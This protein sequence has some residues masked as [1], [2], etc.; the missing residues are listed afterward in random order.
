[1]VFASLPR[2]RTREPVLTDP[3]MLAK[4]ASLRCADE[5]EGWRWGV[6]STGRDYAPGEAAAL[7]QRER[8][9]TR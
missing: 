8:E 7:I 5:I 2:R 6:R 3:H 1:M 9:V 4:I